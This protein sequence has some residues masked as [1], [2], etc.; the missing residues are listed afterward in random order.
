M[1]GLPFQ[2]A[3]NAASEKARNAAAKI[4]TEASAIEQSVSRTI[5]SAEKAVTKGVGAAKGVTVDNLHAAESL[6]DQ[7][8]KTF[9]KSLAVAKKDVAAAGSAVKKAATQTLKSAEKFFENEILGKR[10]L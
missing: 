8:K 9:E 5:V 7:W 3:W 4:A 6:A 2:Q 1:F 10:P